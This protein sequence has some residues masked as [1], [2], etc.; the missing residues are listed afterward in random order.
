[1]PKFTD[2]Y[3]DDF[4]YICINHINYSLLIKP[5]IPK[6]IINTVVKTVN[7]PTLPNY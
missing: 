6:E 2:L 4:Q 7:F 5:H 1:M 3:G